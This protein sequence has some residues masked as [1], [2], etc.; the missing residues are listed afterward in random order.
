MD[1]FI[2]LVF[3]QGNFKASIGVLGMEMVIDREQ[4]Y[5]LYKESKD[6]LEEANKLFKNIEEIRKEEKKKKWRC[7]NGRGKR[8]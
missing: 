4:V 5:T 8:K 1:N 7:K 3:G 2:R 6:L